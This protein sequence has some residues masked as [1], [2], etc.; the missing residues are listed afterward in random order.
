MLIVGDGS[1]LIAVWRSPRW[2]ELI[3]PSITNVLIF[4]MDTAAIVS[5][6]VEMD[7]S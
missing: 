4:K 5:Q 2:Q 6:S 7:A 1:K 3:R